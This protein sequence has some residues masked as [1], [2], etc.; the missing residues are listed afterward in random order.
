MIFL[1][2]FL[3]YLLPIPSFLLPDVARSI[4]FQGSAFL[5]LAGPGINTDIVSEL[6]FWFGNYSWF[7]GGLIFALLAYTPIWLLNN[8]YIRTYEERLLMQI[9]T[10]YFF[11]AGYVMQIR[12]ASR[13][14]FYSLVFIFLLSF[15]RKKK[16]NLL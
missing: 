2:M 15:L 10:I 4:N 9:S 12:S 1:G 7:I 13:Y 8:D 3:I 16:S 14:F 5:G 11:G 6:I